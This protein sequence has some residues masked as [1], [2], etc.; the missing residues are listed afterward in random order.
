MWRISQGTLWTVGLLLD[1]LM[2]QGRQTWR[3][4]RMLI[5]WLWAITGFSFAV[6]FFIC[7]AWIINMIKKFLLRHPNNKQ[8]TYTEVCQTNKSQSALLVYC[9]IFE[10]MWSC[11]RCRGIVCKLRARTA[12]LTSNGNRDTIR[13]SAEYSVPMWLGTFRVQAYYN[14][15]FI[16][17]ILVYVFDRC[18]GNQCQSHRQSANGQ[19]N[20]LA[21][22]PEIEDS[23]VGG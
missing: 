2:G 14:Y 4:I 21:D 23:C 5:S 13:H 11:W 8:T 7:V 9:A 6:W 16:H 3:S 12:N 18:N 1:P 20:W 17:S 19:P 10:R 15:M 22:G